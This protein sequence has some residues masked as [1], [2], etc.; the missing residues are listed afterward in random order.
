[1]YSL[2]EHFGT[3]EDLQEL[4]S[5]IH[6][7][8]MYLMVDVVINDMAQAIHG[9]MADLSAA[10]IDWSSLF[11][12]NDEKYYHPYCNVTNWSDPEIYQNCWFGVQ[13]V[14]LP[15]LR[16]EDDI[17]VSM[18]QQWVSELVGNYSIGG[19]RIDATKHVDNPYLAKFTEVSGVFTMGEV[20]TGDTG[21]VCGYE[22]FVTGLLNFPIYFPAIQA[23]T[24]GDMPGLA[25]KVREVQTDCEDFTRLGTFLENHDIPRFAS[26]IKDM[27]VSLRTG[28]IHSA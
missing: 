4:A 16:T 9:T 17:V 23:F 6:K 28:R 7:R 14:A 15:D 19:L 27:A 1:M 24:A 22:Y 18:I 11:P 5:E 13:A 8:D 3:A 20:Y 21:L 2:N 10:G 26:L 25:A 12:F